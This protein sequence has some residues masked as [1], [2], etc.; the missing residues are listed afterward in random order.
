MASPVAIPATPAGHVLSVWLNAIN[1]GDSAK[2]QNY[3]DTYHRQSKPQNYLYLRQITGDLSVLKVEKNDPNEISVILGE[4]KADDV[5]RAQ[6]KTDS[7]DPTKII[8]SEISGTDRTADLAIPRLSQAGALKGLNERADALV[9]QDKFSGAMLAESHGKIVFEKAWGLADREAKIPLTT[10]AKFRMGSM[11][12]MFTAVSVLQLVAKGK[13]SLEGTVGQYVP[14]YPN[15]KIASKVTIRMLLTHTGGTGDIFTDEFTKHRLEL[16]SNADYVKLYGKRAPEFPPG[17]DSN[18]SNYG[19]VLLGYIVEKV[20]GE[21]YY[22]YVRKH[23]FVPSGMTDS[24]SLPEDVN[25]PGRVKGYT[26]KDGKWVSNADTLP[27]RGT[28]AGGGYSTLGDLLRFAHALMDGKLLPDS[29]RDAATRSE[30]KENWYGYGFEIH[31]EGLAHSYG[32]TGGAPGMSAELRIYPEAKTVVIVLSNL[33]PPMV[34]VSYYANRM[35][36]RP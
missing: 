32:H 2:L 31:G 25:V 30:T 24:G 33:D 36:L 12:K 27:Y 16:K 21:D 5:L 6:Y 19:F 9:A 28:A 23:I 20:S 35:P 8:F 17:T 13:L 22:D 11:N 4:A 7:S 26:R 15:K 3:I 29:L 10:N 34:V 1:S 14:D 18:Y